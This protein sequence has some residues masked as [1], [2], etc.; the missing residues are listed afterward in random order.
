MTRPRLLAALILGALLAPDVAT[1]QDL[2]S[3]LQSSRESVVLIRCFDGLGRETGSGT[4]FLVQSGVVATNEHVVDG[5]RRVEVQYFDKETTAALG[6]LAAD[7][8]NDLALLAVPARDLPPVILAQ[9]G[10]I[11]AGDRILVLGNPMGLAGTIS[12][13]IVA[14][15]RPDGLGGDDG[16]F[17]RTPLLQITAPISP[18]SS[19]SPV[20]G[21]SGEV[22]GVAVGQYVYGQN[23]N[24]AIPTASLVALMARMQPGALERTYA[25][26]T[27]FGGWGLVRNLAISIVFFGLLVVAL[28]RA[29]G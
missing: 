3:L 26:P 13:G 24:F 9:P 18:G 20:L 15:I 8:G 25:G 22:I 29:R 17:E 27:R 4:G 1:T 23:L 10:T 5:A 11:E 6:V 2:K 16:F 14:A 19:G 12:D 21:A 28:R 7:E